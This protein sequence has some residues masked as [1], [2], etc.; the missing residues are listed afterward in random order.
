M[1]TTERHI[2]VAGNPGVGFWQGIATKRDLTVLGIT[3]DAYEREGW[4]FATYSTD[5]PCARGIG[6]LKGMGSSA[7]AHLLG[8]VA[9]SPIDERAML[10]VTASGLAISRDLVV[11]PPD[12][13]HADLEQT[14]LEIG[15]EAN[16][17]GLLVANE[18]SLG[19]HKDA[20]EAI[21]TAAG[22][23]F[24]PRNRLVAHGLPQLAVA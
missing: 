3:I 4:D 10:V 14:A 23:V 9:E 5:R 7:R 22:V 17:N 2:E 11:I 24:D 6:A 21:L 18:H 1:N 12:A 16:R 20:S 13:L 8:V 19:Q 15:F